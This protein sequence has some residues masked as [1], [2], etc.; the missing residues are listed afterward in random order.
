MKQKL[1]NQQI[2]DLDLINSFDNFD[3]HYDYNDRN[4]EIIN[5]LKMI[6]ILKLIFGLKLL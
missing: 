2:Q 1:V 6:M 3:I 4:N 5:K